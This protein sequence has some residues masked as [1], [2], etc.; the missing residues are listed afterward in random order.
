MLNCACGSQNYDQLLT[1]VCGNLDPSALYKTAKVVACR[2][3]GHVFNLLTKEEEEG[4]IKYYQEEYSVNNINSCNPGGD[5]PGSVSKAS[6]SRY[7]ALY[8]ALDQCLRPSDAILDVGCAT[9]GFLSFL[10]AH[11][12]TELYGTDFCSVFLMEAKKKEGI[13]IKQGFAE[14]IPFDRTFDLLIADQVVEH[15]FD[16]NLT[17]EEVKKHLRPG[18]RF[19]I[20]VPDA[21]RYTELA[22]FDFYWFLLREH[23]QHFDALH[24]EMLAK[25]HGFTCEKTVRITNPMLNERIRL[26][27]LTMIFRLGNEKPLT[28]VLAL[29][30]KDLRVGIQKYVEACQR[31]LAQRQDFMRKLCDSGVPFYCWGACREFLYLYENTDLKKC[32][33]IG[34]LDDIPSKQTRTV[35]GM[36]IASSSVLQNSTANVLITAFAHKD[37]MEEKLKKMNFRGNVL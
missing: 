4:T 31:S 20:S 32:N 10:K 25:R 1:L 21:E 5:L 33:I 36:K 12:H 11:G 13:I 3:C 7:Q 30:P 37:I 6:L 23:V 24:L 15:L 14:N 9:G 8:D 19:C 22:W 34:L 29:D 18:G 16:P 17:F 27:N 2:D 26:P 35:G 28:P